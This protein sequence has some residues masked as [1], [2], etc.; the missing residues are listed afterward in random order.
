MTEMIQPRSGDSP[1]HHGKGNL[2]AGCYNACL[3]ARPPQFKRWQT[4]KLSG[5]QT[6]AWMDNMFWHAR[7]L[8]LA[9]QLCNSLNSTQRSSKVFVCQSQ[10]EMP[11]GLFRGDHMSK[12]DASHAIWEVLVMT[13]QHHVG[14]GRS[15]PGCC[16][17]RRACYKLCN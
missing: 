7:I 10:R 17:V 12:Q 13:M 15:T 1:A 3:V 2:K 16:T 5:N 11:R 14:G 8:A 9:Q 6:A 4:I